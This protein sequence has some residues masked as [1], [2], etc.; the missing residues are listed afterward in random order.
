MTYHQIN[1]KDLDEFIKI[2]DK[3]GHK[4]E[5]REGARDAASNLVGF[6]DILI[7]MDM[8]ERRKNDRLKDEPDG[9]AFPGE[10]RGCSLCSRHISGDMWW[11]KWG[12]KCMDCHDA[13]KKKIIPG[14]CFK[15]HNNEKH[16]T[17]SKIL[18]KFDIPIQTLKKMVREGEIKVR[19]VKGNGTMVVLR[20]ENPSLGD[21]LRKEKIELEKRRNNK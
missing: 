2:S 10:G 8:E 21:V 14:Y 9:F 19:T 4:Y 17:I 3:E 13:F 1:D 18:W 12:Q 15:D 5:T 6:F 7:Q 11:D 16:I 20:K